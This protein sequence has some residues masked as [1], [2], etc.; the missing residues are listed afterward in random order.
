[1][2]LPIGNQTVTAVLVT[3]GT[4]DKLGV[5]AKVETQV[6]LAGCSFQPLSTVETLGDVDQVTSHWKL[7]APT[8][9]DLTA[10]DSLIT[11]WDGLRYDVDGDPLVW[12]DFFGNISHQEVLFRRATG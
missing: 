3:E 7:F 5:P 2:T 8:S 6:T 11:P 12:R 1:V 9:Q 10:I 4:T